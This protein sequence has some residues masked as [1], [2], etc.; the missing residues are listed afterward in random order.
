MLGSHLETGKH[1]PD[2]HTKPGGNDLSK[3]SAL[4]LRGGGEIEE[5]ITDIEDSALLNVSDTSFS[6]QNIRD[7]LFEAGYTIKAIS[8]VLAV[9]SSP[10]KSPTS[11]TTESNSESFRSE[12]E[13]ECAFDVLK[14]IR[15]KNV[16][17]IVIGTLNINSLASKFEQL[18][19]LIGTHLDILTIQE[20]KL[21]HS[22]PPQQFC[23]KGY[24]EPY[25][26]DRNKEGG[27]VLIYVRE[28]IPSKQLTKHNFTKNVEGILL[29][30]NL[31]KAKLLFFGGY[32]SEYEVH[33]L[34]NVT[35]W[36]K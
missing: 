30:I 23:L 11:S 12:S 13:G 14:E 6:E 35:F 18:S 3:P 24:S 4:R 9:K 25:R 33:G 34:T 19:E 22:F 5:S 2:L 8:D 32:R 15:T 28:D 27:G 7:T 26:L 29:E 10:K 20:T 16:N 17:R 31:R 36:S 21:D 1:S